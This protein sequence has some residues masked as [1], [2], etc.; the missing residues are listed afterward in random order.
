[1][2]RAEDFEENA[3]VSV[4]GRVVSDEHGRLQ[5]LVPPEGLQSASSCWLERS[6]PLAVPPRCPHCGREG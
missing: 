3:K 2:L 5:V 6:I 1:M 4:L